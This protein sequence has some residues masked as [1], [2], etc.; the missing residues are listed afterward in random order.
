MDIRRRRKSKP[1][2][3]PSFAKAMVMIP[4]LMNIKSRKRRNKKRKKKSSKKGGKKSIL[5]S[6]WL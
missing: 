6:F 2:G 3:I 1:G 4:H 5:F